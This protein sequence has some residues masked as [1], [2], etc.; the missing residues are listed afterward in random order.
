MPSVWVDGT[1]VIGFSVAVSGAADLLCQYIEAKCR[2]TVCVRGRVCAL[3]LLVPV[4]PSVPGLAYA[5]RRCTWVCPIAGAACV[6]ASS[7]PLS[8]SINRQL[9]RM[10]TLHQ[11][12][13]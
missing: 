7:K 6:D 10:I 13:P 2:T 12:G 9:T 8:L 3:V 5:P 11:G 4:P 1:I